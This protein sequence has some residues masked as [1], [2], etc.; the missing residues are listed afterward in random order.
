MALP[1]AV[2]HLAR[3]TCEMAGGHRSAQFAAC[4]A[5]IL[6]PLADEAFAAL[7]ASSRFEDQMLALSRMINLRW[8]KVG[9]YT[10]TS[11]RIY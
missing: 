2:S 5:R 7:T 3:R 9:I 11:W 4:V 8:G 1:L 10:I 6:D